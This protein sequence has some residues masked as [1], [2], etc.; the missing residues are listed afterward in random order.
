MPD[1]PSQPQD[2][3]EMMGTARKLGELVARHPAIKRYAEAQEAL[4]RDAEATRLLSE[5]ERRAQVLM[6][7]EQMGQVVGEAER[8]ELESLQ[9]QIASNIRVKAYS[10]AQTEMTDLLRRVSQ[11]WQRPVA[12]AQGTGA[13][14]GTAQ[15]PR[16]VVQ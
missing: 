11:A 16:T 13:E 7:N 4:S 9:Q 14:A 15:G 8:R 6:R 10:I 2:Q 5:F 3:N 12:E 1:D